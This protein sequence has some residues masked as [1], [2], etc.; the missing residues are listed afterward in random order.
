M[1]TDHRTPAR[2]RSER[3]PAGRPQ[4]WFARLRARPRIQ[5]LAVSGAVLGP[6]DI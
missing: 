1:T 3:G 4:Q 5:G 6:P 2:G